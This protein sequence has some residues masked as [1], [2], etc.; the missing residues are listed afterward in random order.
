MLIFHLANQI[1]AIFCYSRRSFWFT[2]AT[3]SLYYV[4]S[5]QNYAQDSAGKSWHRLWGLFTYHTLW[6]RAG[7]G[8]LISHDTSL[9]VI[10]VLPYWTV[11]MF[12]TLK[13]SVKENGR[14]GG[15]I[16][17]RIPETKRVKVSFFNILTRTIIFLTKISDWYKDWMKP[18]FV[19]LNRIRR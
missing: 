7:K 8:S 19:T 12:S 18:L 9:R 3:A 6:F 1:T 17:E 4:W 11:S 13:I 2:V 5:K 14:G 10:E 16:I 15:D